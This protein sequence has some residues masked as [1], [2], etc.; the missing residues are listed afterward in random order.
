MAVISWCALMSVVLVA[1]ILFVVLSAASDRRRRRAELRAES[2]PDL[3]ERLG[4][5]LEAEGRGL[6]ACAPVF[7]QLRESP[8]RAS[9]AR[10]PELEERLGRCWDEANEGASGRDRVDFTSGLDEIRMIL[11]V[12]VEKGG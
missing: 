5:V 12:L 1:V 7:D 10:W 11:E 8:A 3:Q 2:V 4:G 9:L 6:L